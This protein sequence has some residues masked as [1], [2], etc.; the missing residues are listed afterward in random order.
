MLDALEQAHGKDRSRQPQRSQPEAN[1]RTSATVLALLPG[2]RS[3][4]VARNL[5]WMLD[6]VLELRA[7]VPD[8]Q[9][10]VCLG[11]T[12]QTSQVQALLAAHPSRSFARVDCGDL[13][14][15][16]GRA[17][18]AFSVSGTVLIDLLWQRMPTVV[19]YRL[20]S[21][22]EA[23][24][25]KRILIAPYFA[26]PNLLAGREVLPEF[27]FA[28]AGPA[29]AV[30]HALARA[31]TDPSWRAACRRGLDGAAQRLWTGGASAR[32]ARAALDLLS[33]RQAAARGT[34]TAPDFFQKK[35]RGP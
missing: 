27:A 12:A 16:L 18:A 6:R 29:Q 22:R 8:L 32:A 1:S 19:V 7:L 2:S 28:G 25:A 11:A 15:C 9:V 20:A 24:L 30:T 4:V 5:P 10:E 31:L 13:H 33:Q 3:S 14:A 34:A 21:R 23:W 26:A 17:R 35:H